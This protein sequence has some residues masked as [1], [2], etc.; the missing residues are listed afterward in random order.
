M[1]H[2]TDPSVTTET[3]APMSPLHAGASEDLLATLDEILSFTPEAASSNSLQLDAEFQ[4]S[5]AFELPEVPNPYEVQAD[6]P[7]QTQEPVASTPA[8]TEQPT[9]QEPAR[10]KDVRAAPYTKPKRRRKRPKDE[11]DYLR[12]KV[13]DLEE[14][15]TKL[16]QSTGRLSPASDDDEE[17][18]S[19]WKQVAERQKEEANKTV[20]ENLKLKA[21]LQG[22]IEIAMRLE[23][24][25]ADHQEAAAAQTFPWNPVKREMDVEEEG[26]TRRPRAPSIADEVLFA[27]LNGSLEAQYAQVD[28]LMR[29]SGIADVNHE[30]LGKIQLRQDQN[31]ISFA[32]RD[33][34]VLPFST[35]SV[36]RIMWSF[37][38]YDSD[39]I[40]GRVQTRVLNND[41]LNATIV[42]TLQ[43]PKSRR[44]E[45]FTRIAVRR[46]FEANRVV[47]VWSGCVEIAGSVFVRLREKGAS[48]T[49]TFDFVNGGAP[50]VSPEG[51]ILRGVVDVKPETVE[52]STGP[53]TQGH[54][55]EMTDLVLGTYHRNFGLIN[56]IMENLLL[57]DLMGGDAR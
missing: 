20:V 5:D 44:T 31:G 50:G 32:H 54:I 48:T 13:A 7:M 33:V 49:T 55:G 15:L 40:P 53:E 43:L 47:V 39:K 46:Y 1:E 28:E 8:A 23:A 35:L 9:Q 45:V 10:G 18:F 11:L 27:E 34:R 52:F 14:E 21:M 56:Q 25:I 26:N 6:E 29:T 37:L 41:H 17:M 51:C 30:M 42:D 16:N 36:A 24:A 4:I 2:Q 38:L 19:R 57:N 3:F 12:A 22:Q